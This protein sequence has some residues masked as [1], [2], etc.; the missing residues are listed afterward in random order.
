MFEKQ[1]ST[2]IARNGQWLGTRFH[3]QL[4]L[5]AYQ[6][7]KPGMPLACERVTTCR[8]R[9]STLFPETL[10][11]VMSLSIFTSIGKVLLQFKHSQAVPDFQQYL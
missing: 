8:V 4:F 7:S 9:A 11:R 10:W 6:H 5:C 2:V 1:S 3:N